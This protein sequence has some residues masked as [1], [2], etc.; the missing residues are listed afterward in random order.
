MAHHFPAKS[1]SSSSY[2]YFSHNDP[3]AM[4]KAAKASGVKKVPQTPWT[5]KKNPILNAWAKGEG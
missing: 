5:K 3:Y 4:T 2:Y 1:Q